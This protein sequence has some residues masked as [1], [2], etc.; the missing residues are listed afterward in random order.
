[1]RDVLARQIEAATRPAV[2]ALLLTLGPERVHRRG[3][4]R[5]ITEPVRRLLLE[6]VRA[7]RAAADLEDRDDILALLVRARDEDGAPM[8]DDE[9][10]T[11][12]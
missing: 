12:S 3:V 7:A 4:L 9:L 5:R 11:S 6:E 10:W 8:A 2:L 1:M